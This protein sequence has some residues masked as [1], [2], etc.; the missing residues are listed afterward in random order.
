MRA[1]LRPN[2]QRRQVSVGQS[3]PAPIGG[4]DASSPLAAMPIQ[5]AQ[6]LD[7]WIPRAG[8][9]ELRRGFVPQ[10][11]GFGSPIETLMPYRGGPSGDLLFAA[12]GGKI[13]DVTTQNAPPGAPAYSGAGS[14]RW[15]STS[16]ANAA[17][18]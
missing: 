9:V 6:I 13:Y 10:Q 2:P 3:I 7:N 16:F 17:G 5:N 12:S 11:T 8:Y 1:A 18:A 14:N 15:N 4:W